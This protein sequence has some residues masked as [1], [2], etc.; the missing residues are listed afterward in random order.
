LSDTTQLERQMY[1]LALLA[2]NKQGYTIDD[3][4]NS[5]DRIGV[6]ISKK[7]ISR[8]IDAISTNFNIYEEEKDNKTHYYLAKFNI[9]N[10]SFNIMDQISLYFN[11]EVLRI[12]SSIDVGRNAF[13]LVDRLI[14]ELPQINRSYVEAL[15]DTF[16]VYSTIDYK[17]KDI[18]PEQLNLIREAVAGKKTL[19]IDYHSFASD[20]TTSR[21]FDP[22]FYELQDGCYHVIGYCHLRKGV[23]DF[24][25]S[26]IKSLK[27]VDKS[28]ERPENFYETYKQ[29][30]FDKLS[31]NESIKL[32][33]QFKREAA[34]YVKE[35]ELLKAD[36]LEECGNGEILFE[37]M[38]TLTPD[39]IK[40]IMGFGGQVKV[41]EPDEV[42][43]EVMRQAKEILESY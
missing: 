6:D 42:K 20:E 10:I 8:D 21:E 11:R 22:Y 24:R 40:W 15:N 9:D 36:K 33:L 23:R 4:K 43:A 41:V 34:R 26:R 2:E 12:Y 37:R 31:G 30:R 27:L 39:I 25:V 18:A 35:Y 28:F 13:E 29:G 38:T 19:H 32:K 14:G 7:T 16:K 1:I 17:E 3:I 5:L